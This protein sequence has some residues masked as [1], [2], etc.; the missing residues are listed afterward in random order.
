M[1]RGFLQRALSTGYLLHA[2][3]PLT[4]SLIKMDAHVAPKHHLAFKVHGVTS[5]KTEFITTAVRIGV[6]KK[7]F[8]G[9]LEYCR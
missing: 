4:Y 6:T 7:R 3:S 1:N 5:Q 9:T 8:Y 2:L